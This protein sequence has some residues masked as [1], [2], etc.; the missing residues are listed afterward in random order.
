MLNFP[1]RNMI[2]WDFRQYVFLFDQRADFE[3]IIPAV[4]SEYDFINPG[5]TD[6][7]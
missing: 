6:V 1:E 7:T 5:L 4:L 2:I 3:K